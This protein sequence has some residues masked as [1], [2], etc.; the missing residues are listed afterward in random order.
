MII[1]EACTNWERITDAMEI[2]STVGNIKKETGA[3]LLVK[4]QLFDA[5]DDKGK[6]HYQWVKDHQ[7]SY[8]QADMLFNFGKDC[9]IEVFFSV[10]G[11]KYVD[12]CERI[13]VKRYKVAADVFFRFVTD[14]PVIKS[15]HDYAD[16]LRFQTVDAVLY[17][18]EGYPAKRMYF[19]PG[20]FQEHDGYITYQGFSD[21]AIGLDAAKIALARGAQIIEKHFLLE[22]NPAFPDNDWSMTQYDLFELVRWEKICRSV[23]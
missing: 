8:E 11:V 14:K 7:L 2:V 13:G 9:G 4:F 12:W 20:D 10:F 19:F 21:H 1:C 15:V 6:P 3:D 22:H 23:L 16:L 17:C 18:P 5:E